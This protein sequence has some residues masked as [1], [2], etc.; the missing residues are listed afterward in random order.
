MRK[1]AGR[2]YASAGIFVQK[3]KDWRID[4]VL[5]LPFRFG[6]AVGAGQ[7]MDQKCPLSEVKQ[8]FRGASPAPA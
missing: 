3:T 1:R 7:K 8:G 4:L 6:A 5:N 2:K